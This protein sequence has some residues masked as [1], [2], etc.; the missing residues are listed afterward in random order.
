MKGVAVDYLAWLHG[1]SRGFREF[2]KLPDATTP[3]G[4]L[5]RYHTEV[6]P[7]RQVA[8]RTCPHFHRDPRPGCDL[9]PNY[10]RSGPCRDRYANILRGGL[11]HPDPACL[12]N[13]QRWG[14]PE[15]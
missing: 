12:W 6:L 5:E 13:R 3:R 7:R 14:A 9:L 1:D 4:V 11:G 8:C 15:G 10:E 2:E